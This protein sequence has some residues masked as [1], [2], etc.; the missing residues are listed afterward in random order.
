MGIK[1]CSTVFWTQK[2]QFVDQQREDF[3]RAIA[4]QRKRNMESDQQK[5]K[6]NEE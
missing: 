5:V 2:E 4:N 1:R 3:R 6:S